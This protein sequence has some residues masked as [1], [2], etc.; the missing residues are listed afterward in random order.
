[1]WT[2]GHLFARLH[3]PL[4]PNNFNAN[5]G[6]YIFITCLILE[7]IFFKSLYNF[8]K[9]PESHLNCHYYS[10]QF[11]KELQQSQPRIIYH[12]ENGKTVW[13]ADAFLNVEVNIKSNPTPL[14]RKKKIFVFPSLLSI[15]GT[16]HIPPSHAQS[17]PGCAEVGREAAQNS[18]VTT[19]PR[20][21]HAKSTWTSR[22]GQRDRP[23]L[24]APAGPD[25]PSRGAEGR[26][27]EDSGRA[28]R[29]ARRG[30]GPGPGRGRG[31]AVTHRGGG[32]GSPAPLTRGGG[33]GAV[34]ASLPFKH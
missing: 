26:A 33:T 31:R 22:R 12:R 1:M 20:Y 13:R 34:A 8:F 28:A 2:S 7:N 29:A 18:R 32:E 6:T 16:M 25:P 14:L 30:S 11:F 21:F 15:R 23:P 27:A 9:I 4:K 10:I 3:Q 19:C 24:E 17:H 5:T